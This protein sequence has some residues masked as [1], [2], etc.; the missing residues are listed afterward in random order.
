LRGLDSNQRPLGYEPNELPSCSTPRQYFIKVFIRIRLVSLFVK[1]KEAI[2]REI[3]DFHKKSIS[4]IVANNL[5]FYLNL[6]MKWLPFLTNIHIIPLPPYKGEEE[7]FKKN[8][9][10]FFIVLLTYTTLYTREIS[11]FNNSNNPY[12]IAIEFAESEKG[13]LYKAYIK[14]G[15]THSFVPGKQGVPDIKWSFCLKN[16]YYIKNP[17]M[18]DRAHNFAQALWRKVSIGWTKEKQ[19]TPD[20][21]KVKWSKKTKRTLPQHGLISKKNVPVESKSLCKDRHFE[22]TENDEEKIVVTGS[23]IE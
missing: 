20:E 7:M 9:L 23:L 19:M 2:L 5:I 14:P 17:T 13:P 1:L 16:V 18:K 8:I 6:Y 3:L 10:S 21:P 4:L 11:F 22:I 12:G 15:A